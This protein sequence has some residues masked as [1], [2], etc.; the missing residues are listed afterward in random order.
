VSSTNSLSRAFLITLA[1]GEEVENVWKSLMLQLV[2]EIFPN[3]RNGSR[4]M[5]KNSRSL[6]MN[7]DAAR[8][9]S[10]ACPGYQHPMTPALSDEIREFAKA[11]PGTSHQDIAVV[12]N[13]NHGGVSEVIGGKRR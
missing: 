7:F 6:P 4:L 11:N 2:C 3:N 10:C 5:L 12:F 1:G 9:R 8:R 13:V